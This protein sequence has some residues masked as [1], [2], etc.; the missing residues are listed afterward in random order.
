MASVFMR[1][2]RTQGIERGI[3]G[4]SRTWIVLGT[5][6]WGLRGLRWALRRDEQV[7]FQEVLRPGEQLIIS[8]R[9]PAG[10]RRKRRG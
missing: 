2:L 1:R 6:A 4:G 3:L 7:L 8:T 5:I 9:T 10:K